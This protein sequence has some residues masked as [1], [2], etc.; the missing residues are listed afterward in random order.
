M[1][2]KIKNIAIVSL[3]FLSLACLPN[4]QTTT[5][6]TDT[7]ISST[8]E[9]SSSNISQSETTIEQQ[10]TTSG[11]PQIT[12]TSND[13]IVM[14]ITADSICGDG[15]IEF[16]EE[17]DDGNLITEDSCDDSCFKTRMVFRSFEKLPSNFGGTFFADGICTMNAKRAKLEGTYKAW[18]SDSDLFSA[19]LFR[20]ESEDFQGWYLLP[21][22]PPKKLAKGWKGL[23]TDFLV[24]WIDVSAAGVEEILTPEFVW[25]GTLQDGTF[26]EGNTC[27]GWT[28][29][30]A[31]S[32][33]QI[34]S[35][36]NWNKEWTEHQVTNC[37]FD[38]KIYCFQ[39]D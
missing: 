1:K 39:V 29:T 14:T 28:T 36:G 13:T 5:D 6:T 9:V 30:D 4:D 7:V 25:T 32:K 24:N 37:G 22:N 8:S 16:P 27:N 18:V 15:L 11:S 3:T 23:T 10:I 21:T 31:N 19:P 2:N 17:C 12:E 35:V 20:F 38:K 26:S 33:A 34:G